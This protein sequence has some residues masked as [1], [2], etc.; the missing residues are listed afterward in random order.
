MID[1]FIRPRELRLNSQG[2]TYRKGQQKTAFNWEGVDDIQVNNFSASSLTVGEV[3]IYPKTG[4]WLTINPYLDLG[5]GSQ[6]LAVKLRAYHIASTG[7]ISFSDALE[8]ASTQTTKER[9]AV[10]KIC[11]VLLIVIIAAFIWLTV[12]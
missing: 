7:R 6:E 9:S 2:F 12:G 4:T 1:P 10:L 8:Q 11:L 5:V 3:D